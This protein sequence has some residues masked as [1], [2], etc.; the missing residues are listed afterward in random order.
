MSTDSLTK[1]Y[2]RIKSTE[3][4]QLTDKLLSIDMYVKYA[5]LFLQHVIYIHYTHITIIT[6]TF[7]DH[8]G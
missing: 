2:G 3:L 1:K 8:L 4:V 6:A 5:P 7:S